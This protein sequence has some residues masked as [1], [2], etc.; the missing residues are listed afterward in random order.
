MFDRS[1]RNGAVVYTAVMILSS[2]PDTA[3]LDSKIDNFFDEED[4]PPEFVTVRDQCQ[5]AR[6]TMEI[7]DYKRPVLSLES[8]VPPPPCM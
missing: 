7:S 3:R 8:T 4:R 1:P 6:P 2:K 5:C